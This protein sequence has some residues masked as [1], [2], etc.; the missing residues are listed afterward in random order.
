MFFDE[1]QEKLKSIE[2]DI[3]TI[4]DYWKNS[5]LEALFKQLDGQSTQEDF[6]QHTEQARLTQGTLSV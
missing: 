2:P 6:W 5:N 1:L 4:K 3:K